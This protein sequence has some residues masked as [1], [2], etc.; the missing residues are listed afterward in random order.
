MPNHPFLSTQHLKG[1]HRSQLSNANISK[2]VLDTPKYLELH[3]S[4]EVIGIAIFLGGGG[5]VAIQGRAVLVAQTLHA[6]HNQM[7]WSL[8][9]W[10]REHEL[11]QMDGV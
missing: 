10:S 6:H 4:Q 11:M 7:T 2:A 5:E 8:R 3:N 1:H 9:D